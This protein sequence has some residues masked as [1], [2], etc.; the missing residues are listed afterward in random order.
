M[1]LRL[2]TRVVCLVTASFA[3]LTVLCTSH[4]SATDTVEV[5]RRLSLPPFAYVAEMDIDASALARGEGAYTGA[6]AYID[7]AADS[8]VARPAVGLNPQSVAVSPDGSRLYVTDAYDPVLH[9]L[10]AETKSEIAAVA[11]PGVEARDP[12]AISTVMK[13]LDSVFSYDLWRT[14]SQGVAC[15]PDG[16]Y[17]LVCSSDGLQVVD[18]ATNE[19]VRTIAGL[20]GGHVAVSFDGKRAYVTSDDFETLPA[21]DFLGWFRLLSEAEDNRLVCLDLSTFE[22]VCEILTAAV[23][24]IA[25]KPDDSQVL[26]SETYKKRVR[27]LDAATLADLWQVSTDPS[28]SIGL[29]FVPSGEKVYVVCSADS[30]WATAVAG[31]T[32]PRLPTADEY[33][34]GVI[35]TAAEE[36]VKRIPL[37]AY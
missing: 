22:A 3:A 19:V 32:V 29:G 20:K 17:V 30:G 35:D 6:A 1:D 27:V 24:G 7:S 5:Q 13:G 12:N 21:R 18:A 37:Q 23:G 8:L 26:I 33:F 25:I 2:R 11:L 14:C 36:I 9:V 31:Q 16:Q 10:D 15:T 4:A 34:C 28:Y